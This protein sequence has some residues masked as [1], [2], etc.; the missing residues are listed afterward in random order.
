MAGITGFQSEI[1]GTYGTYQRVAVDFQVNS[2]DEL[3]E[4][5]SLYLRPGMNV[6]VEWGHS[7][8]KKFKQG[9]LGGEGGSIGKKNKGQGLK[10]MGSD[11]KSL[12]VKY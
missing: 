11:D 6:L 7:I 1:L 12:S 2:L 4:L 10:A 5:E 9:E 8:Y 3:T